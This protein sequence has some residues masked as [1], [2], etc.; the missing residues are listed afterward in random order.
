[1]LISGTTADFQTIVLWL[2]PVHHVSSRYGSFLTG[3]FV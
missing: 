3:V 2:N 1:M